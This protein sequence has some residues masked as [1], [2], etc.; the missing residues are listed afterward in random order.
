MDHFEDL[1]AV[2]K[3]FAEVNVL[4]HDL[5]LAYTEQSLFG[6]LTEPVKSTAC[7]ERG[8]VS[9]SCAEDFSER[10]HSDNHVDVAND[11]GQ[12]GHE[13]VQNGHSDTL[14]DTRVLTN[15][16]DGFHVFLLV[17][18]G[19]ITT[20]EDV[21]DILEHLLVDNLGVDKDEGGWFVLNSSLHEHCLYIFAPVHHT[22]ALDDFNLEHFLIGDESCKSGETLTP[23]S[24]HT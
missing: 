11:T 23:R 20:I 6:P 13:H 17:E 9:E 22:I 24:T 18:I 21:V 2:V 8:E 5:T 4:L 19:Y 1:N 12:V 10:R 14:I 16:L 3:I 7:N 15:L